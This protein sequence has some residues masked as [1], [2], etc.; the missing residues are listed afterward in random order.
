MIVATRTCCCSVTTASQIMAVIAVI[1][2]VAIMVVDWIMVSTKVSNICMSVVAGLEV[3][4]C[5]LVFVGCWT[6][7]HMLL[8][9][10]LFIQAFNCGMIIATGINFFI[11]YLGAYNAWAITAWISGYLI[12]LIISCIVLDCHQRC[13]KYLKHKRNLERRLKQMHQTGVHYD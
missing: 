1:P 12:S 4:A 5:V 9:P 11:I 2:C 6:T 10:I 8:A 13:Y 7:N 3:V